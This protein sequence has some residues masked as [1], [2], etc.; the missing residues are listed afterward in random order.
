MEN[1]LS[2]KQAKGVPLVVEVKYGGNWGE[3]K[4]M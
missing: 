3:L 4:S 2:Q 1:I